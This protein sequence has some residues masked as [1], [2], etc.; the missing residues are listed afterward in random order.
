V[1]SEISGNWVSRLPG[2]I[3]NRNTV[4]GGVGGR[5]SCCLVTRQEM[6]SKFPGGVFHRPQVILFSI[7][8]QQPLISNWSSCN[9]R[10][11]PAVP[12]FPPADRVFARRP[13]YAISLQLI[14]SS[15]DSRYESGAASIRPVNHDDG[16]VG[17]FDAGLARKCGII[18][19]PEPSEKN[20]ARAPEQPLILL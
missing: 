12:C 1:P 20:S 4:P 8:V 14:D 5:F 18:P 7:A 3:S 16:L 13:T 17:N 19:P 10:T 15:I 9:W 6:L 11:W 2:R